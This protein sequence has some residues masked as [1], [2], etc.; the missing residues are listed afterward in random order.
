MQE[1]K[2]NIEEKQ[3]IGQL[4]PQ[5]ADVVYNWCK[6]A[7]FLEISQQSDIYEGQI[8]RG[9]RRLDELL[10]QMESASKVIG[11]TELAQ[12]FVDASKLLKK[13][14]VFAASLYL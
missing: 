6:G 7:S 4:K 14:I 2:I 12:K 13:G 1:S 5:L 11:N 10:K 8:I 3:Y 9:M